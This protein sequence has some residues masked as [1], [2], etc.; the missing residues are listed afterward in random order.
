[1]RN[2]ES[3]IKRYVST[4]TQNA[5]LL[6]GDWGKGK[7]YYYRN[8]LEG[9]LQDTPVYSDN[10][11]KY[12]PVYVSLFGL[13]SLDEIQVKITLDLLG[14]RAYSRWAVVRFFS[15]RNIILTVALTKLLIK[16]ILVVKGFDKANEYL[17]SATKEV[18]KQ[19]DTKDIFICF[20][21]L[22][23][24]SPKL[25]IGE[26]IGYINSLIENHMK[27]L[28][29][30]NEKEIP[31]ED[32]KRYKEKIVNTSIEYIP[33]TEKVIA[34]IIST[35]YSEFGVYQ[36]FLRSQ[37]AFLVQLANKT[38][39]NYRHHIFA[40]DCL[41]DIF[42]S[43]KTHV[44]DSNMDFAEKCNQEIYQ[45]GKFCLVIAIEFKA[46]RLSNSDKSSMKNSDFLYQLRKDTNSSK[47]RIEL[48]LESYFENNYD[49][50]Y[51]ESIFNFVL[52]INEFIVETFIKEF[53]NNYKLENGR[54][55]PQYQL[56]NDLEHWKALKLTDAQYKDMTSEMLDYAK[57]GKYLLSEY[58][59]I[60]YYCVRF[61]NPQNF[62]SEQLSK[63]LKKG[64]TSASERKGY[65]QSDSHSKFNFEHSTGYDESQEE[66]RLHGLEILEKYQSDQEIQDKETIVETFLNN[67]ENL[68]DKYHSDEQF[69]YAVTSTPIFKMIDIDNFIQKLIE[70]NP[71]SIVFL[72]DMLKNRYA[73]INYRDE[74]ASLAELNR[75]LCVYLTS[76]TE[77]TRQIWALNEFQKQL[78][79]IENRHGLPLVG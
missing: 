35:Q 75:K 28:I 59:Q 57:D 77:K 44:L 79:T 22:E 54:I 32:F 50:K 60:Y 38:G 62:V 36:E 71:F 23:R 25:D 68:H 29:I 10:S 14:T 27:V 65:L 39:N 13:Q 24:R 7:T 30:C 67:L 8:Q 1:M 56:L 73:N 74:A 2:L 37:M 49:Y 11:K 26:F 72:T 12:K 16:G 48:L 15:K 6:T 53:K 3:V 78:N 76:H 58:Q 52:G 40:L 42:A 47:S 70:L 18:S 41:H 9:L 63:E 33:D 4:Q 45:I 20:D 46:S 34:S 64:M 61:N 66:I 21:D 17:S 5:I 51:Y 31:D 55:L 43:L 19:I 69:R